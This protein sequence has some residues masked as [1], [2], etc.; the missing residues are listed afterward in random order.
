VNGERRRERG[1]EMEDGE[2]G[3][4]VKERGDERVREEEEGMFTKGNS[5]RNNTKQHRTR[6]THN[7]VQ[8]HSLCF[9]VLDRS[10]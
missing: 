10:V 4:V 3:E 8:Y 1:D 2:K 9:L 6:H 7:T 5:T